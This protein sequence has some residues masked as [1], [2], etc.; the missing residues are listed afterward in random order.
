MVLTA[1]QE[2]GLKIAIDRYKEGETETVI[3]GYA[4]SGKSTL[5][6]FII[7]A[8]QVDPFLDVCYVAYTGKAAN[9]LQSKGNPNVRTLH[10]LLYNPKVFGETISFE[11]KSEL[12]E[13]YKIIVLDE[14]SMISQKMWQ[15]LL[16]FGVYVIACGDPG[17]LPPL[18]GE[19]TD[20]IH[21][22]H[23]FLD[24]IM[25]QAQ[26][27]EIIRMSMI[28]REGKELPLFKGNEVQVFTYNDLNQGM[29]LWADQILCATN[30]NKNNLNHTIRKMLGREGDL[31]PGEKIM[32]QSNQWE[33]FSDKGTALT[34]GTSLFVNSFYD[35][36]Q[37][38]S[39]SLQK[40]RPAIQLKMVNATS[41]LGDKFNLLPLDL[42]YLRTGE[43]SFTLKE[44]LS[45]KKS[46]KYQH[47]NP[48]PF[49]YSYAITTWKAQGSEWD[50][51]LLLEENHPFSKED[52]IKYMY[53]GITRAAEKLVVIKK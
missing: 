21:K 23:V 11:L 26:E 49:D 10:K 5:V 50:K 40:G 36:K 42:L 44:H 14:V 13:E 27:S 12:D 17:Q 35:K 53:T 48:I 24:E 39:P 37:F 9:V 20:V 30:A 52:H 22:P 31:V 7:D 18:A 15:E 45:I 16:S 19:Q 6:K 28:V 3:S 46:K 41:E 47:V 32:C 2:E 29:L 8:L 25:R 34:N 43:E 1:K 38:Y 33:V 4:G 51:V